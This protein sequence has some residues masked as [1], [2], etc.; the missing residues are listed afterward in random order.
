MQAN[1]DIGT[2]I[3]DS[4]EIL[5]QN[6]VLL[7]GMQ[8]L[9]FTISLIFSLP[10]NFAGVIAQGLGGAADLDSDVIG[11]I[12]IF[13]SLTS[14]FISF[15]VTTYLT[16]GYFTVM[17]KLVRGQPASF[18][19]MVVPFGKYLNGLG[20]L[21]LSTIA[22][23]IGLLFCVVPGIIILLGVIFALLLVADKNLGVINALK[24]SWAMTDGIKLQI[25]ILVLV[26]IFILS[27]LVLLLKAF[28]GMVRDA[29]DFFL[30]VYSEKWI[31][32]YN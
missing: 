32:L 26:F 21:L 17:L 23:A 9:M 1:W 19:D 16:L 8:V 12:I 25:F 2:L 31:L 30:N 22:Y 24:T 29:A 13:I 5:K 10:S 18:I 3:Q 6:P 15:L 20:A 11:F 4:F 27:L 28:Q 14:S 7:I